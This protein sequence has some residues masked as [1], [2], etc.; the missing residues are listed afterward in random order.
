MKLP[1]KQMAVYNAIQ[2]CQRERGYTPS[3]REIGDII[4]TTGNTAAVHIRR[5]AEKGI[6]RRI[7]TRHIILGNLNGE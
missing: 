2:Q 1:E 7:H 6:L 3:I 5:M 4:G